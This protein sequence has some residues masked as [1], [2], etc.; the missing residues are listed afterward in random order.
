MPRD[1]SFPV[2][3]YNMKKLIKDLGLSMEKI[4][5]CKNGYMLYWKDDIDLDYCKFCGEARYK[6]TRECNPNRKKT[7]YAM[8][9]YLPITPRLQRLYASQVTAE[10]MT[11]HANHQ[12]EEDPCATRL[13]RRRGG[14]LTKHTPIL[15]RSHVMLDW[16]CALTGSHRMGSTIARTLV[17]PLYLH[18]TIFHREYA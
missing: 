8:L 16:I 18:R 12:T 2:D 15:Q 14:I 17:V 10:Q 3:Y 5:A 9:R 7:P 4:D 11:W 6:P 1:H 13:K